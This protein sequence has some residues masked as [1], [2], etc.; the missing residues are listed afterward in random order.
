MHTELTVTKILVLFV[1]NEGGISIDTSLLEHS[2]GHAVLLTMVVR[3]DGCSFNYAH[4]RYFWMKI[5]M[6][7]SEI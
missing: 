3:L 5:P 6:K 1:Q 2:L 7:R 4:Q